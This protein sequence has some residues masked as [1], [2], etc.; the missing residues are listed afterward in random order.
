MDCHHESSRHG[1]LETGTQET[2]PTTEE[3]DNGAQD[4]TPSS[5][6]SKEEGKL[7]Y[8]LR[9]ELTESAGG[10]DGAVRLRGIIEDC[11]AFGLTC[12]KGGVAF[13]GTEED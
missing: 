1:G 9:L 6:C 10:V 5:G 7:G 11:E 13:H 2:S 12:Q 3:T 4:E 8:V